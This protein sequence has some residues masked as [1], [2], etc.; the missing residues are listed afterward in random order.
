MANNLTFGKN[1]VTGS[2]IKVEFLPFVE[3]R[4]TWSKITPLNY[5]PGM[6]LDYYLEI[7]ISKNSKLIGSEIVIIFSTKN[8]TLRCNA[9]HHEGSVTRTVARNREKYAIEIQ[10]I[11]NLA[12]KN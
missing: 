5:L 11:K 12:I 7:M 4:H 6:P 2:D 10:P 9:N 3:G 1:N 8:N